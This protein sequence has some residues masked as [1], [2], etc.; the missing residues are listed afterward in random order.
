MIA[1]SRV[2]DD[3]LAREVASRFYARLAAAPSEGAA[4]ALREA[5]LAVRERSPASDWAAFRVL[6]R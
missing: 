6:V 5:V 4:G 1:A 3:A 2:V